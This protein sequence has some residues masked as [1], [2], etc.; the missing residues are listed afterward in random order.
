MTIFATISSLWNSICWLILLAIAGLLAAGF[1]RGPYLSEREGRM[2]KEFELPQSALLI[3]LALILWLAALRDSALS[4]AGLWLLAGVAFGFLGDLCMAN[5]F[6]RANH[7]LHG[8]GAFGTGHLF[9]LLAFREV[10]LRFGLHDLTAYAV[11]LVVTWAIAIGAWLAFVRKPGGDSLQYAALG[12]AL[13][14]GGVAAYALGMGLQRSAFLPTGIGTLLFMGSDLLL[15]ARLF[16]GKRFRYIG[17]LI[18]LSYI[19]A[20]A[21][22]VTLGLTALAA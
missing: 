12:Y 15:A 21:L 7:V 3:G 11:A 18:W 8:I 20:Q 4:T 22:I 14:L 9:Y 19:V 13:L 6:Q 17:D 10:A 2:A 16:S 1:V 5:V